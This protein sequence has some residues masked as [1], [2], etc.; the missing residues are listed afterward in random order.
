M[1][2]TDTLMLEPK[3]TISI[4]DAQRAVASARVVTVQGITLLQIDSMS[5][6][7][8]DSSLEILR[9]FR[10][11][12]RRI[13]LCDTSDLVVGRQFGAG[14]VEQGG[15]E[16]LISCGI[17]GRNVAI[18]ARDSGLS[19]A[20]VVVCNK[21]EAAC[22]VL[23]CRLVP[24]DTVMLLGIDRKTCDELVATLEQ[25]LSPRLAA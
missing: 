11:T 21:A 3:R 22:D 13:V 17:S 20:N 15:A 25:R 8:L 1:E 5:R 18:G 16:L 2:W 12:G 7:E 24:G 6:E 23:S 4:A 9:G 14:I 10:A 19:L